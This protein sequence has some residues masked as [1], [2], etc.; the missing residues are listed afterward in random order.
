MGAL[1]D[2]VAYKTSQQEVKSDGTTS[3]SN[4]H[5]HYSNGIHYGAL[6]YLPF[7]Y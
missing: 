4:Y 1:L 6:D 3:Q 2:F 7:N 5:L